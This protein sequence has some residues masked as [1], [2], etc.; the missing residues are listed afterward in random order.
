MAEPE[1]EPE[2]DPTAWQHEA[3]NHAKSKKWEE[4]KLCVLPPPH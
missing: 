3:I 4:L 1:P 2:R